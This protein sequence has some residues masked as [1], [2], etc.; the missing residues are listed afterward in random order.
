MKAHELERK[1][2]NLH[3]GGML[4][5]L[6]L[7]LEQAQKEKLGYLIFLEML[8]ED[9]VNRR[10]QKTMANR[11][12][13]AQFEEQKNLSDFDFSYNPK[14]PAQDVRDLATCQFI[15]KKESVLICGPV[16]VGKSHIAQALGYAACQMGYDVLYTKTMHL[17]QDLGGGHADGTV[18]KRLRKYIKPNLLIIDDFGLREFSS[19]QAEDLYELICE[20][21]RTGSLIV[22]SN[23]APGD[24]YGLFPNPV[25]AEGALD[26]L[27]N[28]SHHLLLTGKSY[29]PLR[30]PGHFNHLIPHIEGDNGSTLHPKS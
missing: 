28:S 21:Y 5:T 13:K 18:E 12:S 30:R 27:I 10:S 11:L 19:L 7:R 24:W 14:I 2:K 4:D 3:L 15:E 17:L 22:A 26:R 16:G 20:R 23:R 8:L 25:L 9:E 6:N 29:R 1:L